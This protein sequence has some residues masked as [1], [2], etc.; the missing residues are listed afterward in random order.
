MKKLFV[1][2]AV[3]FS[4]AIAHADEDLRTVIGA[5]YSSHLQGMKDKN[6]RTAINALHPESPA[7]EQAKASIAQTMASFDLDYKI[8][9]FSALGT[10]GDFAVVRVVLQTKKVAGKP[11]FEDNE[12]DS[13]QIF[14]KTSEGQWRIWSSCVLSVKPLNQPAN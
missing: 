3:M 13:F 11:K 1:V 6:F 7:Y 14:R 8:V 12:L 5:V 9:S 2:F 4:V 10:S